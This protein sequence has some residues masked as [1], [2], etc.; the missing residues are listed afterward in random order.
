MKLLTIILGLT[1]I[2]SVLMAFFKV[3]GNP[4]RQAYNERVDVLKGQIRGGIATT[5]RLYSIERSFLE[6][7]KTFPKYCKGDYK[8]LNAE[9]MFKYRYWIEAPEMKKDLQ[10]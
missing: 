10:K 3:L 7:K 4:Q 5:N 8:R 6:L 1:A 9:F 2:F